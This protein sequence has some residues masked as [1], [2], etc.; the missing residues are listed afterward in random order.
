MQD[1][2]DSWQAW[3]GCC[4]GGLLAQAVGCSSMWG[5][6]C[7]RLLGGQHGLAAQQA[8]QQLVLQLLRGEQVL[9]AWVLGGTWLRLNP[10]KG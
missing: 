2:S 9:G 4:R 7:S 10:V 6:C 8:V 1:S 5:G 3:R